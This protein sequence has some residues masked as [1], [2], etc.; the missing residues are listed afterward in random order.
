M[1][2]QQICHDCVTETAADEKS[3][4]TSGSLIPRER[5]REIPI[6]RSIVM[7]IVLKIV[8]IWFGLN[9]AIPAFIIY[10][11]SPHLRHR[12]FRITLR[13]FVPPH[14]RR[15]VHQLVEASHHRH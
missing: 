8:G 9:L 12:L 15:L 10:Q 6:S 2:P 1:Q 14:Q 13:L 3:A 7:S 5:E 11:R 4:K